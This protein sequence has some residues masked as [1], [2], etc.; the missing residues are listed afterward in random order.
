MGLLDNAVAPTIDTYQAPVTQSTSTGYEAT[1]LGAPAEVQANTYQAQDATA[2]TYQ[3]TEQSAAETYNPTKVSTALSGILA[4]NSDYLKD[5]RTQALQT[6]NRR[7]LA[8]SSI[9]A[10]AGVQAGIR[11][12]LPVAQGDANAMNSAGQFNAGSVNA[13]N[14]NNANFANQASSAN[15]NAE[16][17]FALSNQSAA[18]RA[19]L[20]NANALNTADQ[21]NANSQN[22]FSQLNQASQTQANQYNATSENEFAL[23][24][25]KAIN[26]ASNEFASANNTASM[27]NAENNM[28]LL[29]ANAEESLSNY[30]T[31]IQRKTALDQI[32]STLVQSGVNNGVFATTDGA[33]NWLSMI[34]DLYPDMGLS[35]VSTLATDAASE[36]A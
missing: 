31:D 24:N 20:D 22:Q 30:S 17:Q 4:R 3:A 16:N 35:V 2:N 9:A 12:A 13:V 28:R 34:G 14:A 36:V 8:N 7:G 6:A 23:N 18:N 21:L 1:L 32:A 27:Q 5:A 10:G 11:S 25:Q 19:S 33:A 29:L 26:Q 15:A